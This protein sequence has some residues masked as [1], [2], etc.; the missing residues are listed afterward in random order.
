MDE[1]RHAVA[2]LRARPRGRRLA[3]LVAAMVV[4]LAAV[5]LVPPAVQN[6]AYHDFADK[7]VVLGIPRFNDVVSNLAFLAAGYAGL[8]FLSGPRGRALLPSMAEAAP[9]TVFFV[10]VMLVAPGSTWYHLAP[11]DETL[12]WDRLAMTVA[13]MALF[14]GFVGDRIDAR[15]GAVIA[16]PLFLALGIASIVWW[17][18]SEDLRFYGWIKF[19]PML[20]IPLICLLFPG[21]ATDF[22]YA[23]QALLLFALATVLEVLDKEVFAA[24]AGQ[25]SGHT[26]KHLAAAIAVYRFV[27]MLRAATPRSAG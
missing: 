9:W 5:F 20:A 15:R 23:L 6:Q 24:T 19:L 4:T 10:G 14:A 8:R 26:L 1:N 13:F 27:V 21:R 11:T 2:R 18:M 16:L 22:R 17:S 7:L 12:V 25:V 3:I